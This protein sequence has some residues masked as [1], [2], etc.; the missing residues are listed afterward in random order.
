[1]AKCSAMKARLGSWSSSHSGSR[2]W[3]SSA[4]GR[5]V[6]TFAYSAGPCVPGHRGQRRVPVVAGEHLVGA[7][8]GLH[9]RDRLGDLLGQQV[10]R[11]AVVADHRLGHRRDRVVDG[12]Q[13]P[14]RVDQDLLVVG[15]EV[16]RDQVGV[17]E[18]VAG[19]AAR[20]RGSRR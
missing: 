17:L 6:N 2:M 12:G 14:G 8:P 1:M 4:C 13:Q 10:E 18:L 7:L 16:A 15:G 9:D 20:W 19:L 11:H 3:A 5:S